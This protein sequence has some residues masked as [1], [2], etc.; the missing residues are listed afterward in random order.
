MEGGRWAHRGILDEV[1]HAEQLDFIDLKRDL[2]YHFVKYIYQSLF[3]SLQY[4]NDLN[5]NGDPENC[6][7]KKEEGSN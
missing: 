3:K 1:T 2:G 5:L 6:H 7:T 4:G